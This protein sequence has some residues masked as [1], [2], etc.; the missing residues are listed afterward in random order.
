MIPDYLSWENGI[1]ATISKKINVLQFKSGIRYDFERQE[2]LT[3]TG[4]LS[5]EILRYTN[6]FQNVSGLLAWE[7][8]ILDH[9]SIS[10]NSGLSMRNPGINELYSFGLPK[11]L[12]GGM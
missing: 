6:N 11:T 8:D 9:Q 3:I 12:L 10:I 4:T 5:K 2:A 7:V 1:F